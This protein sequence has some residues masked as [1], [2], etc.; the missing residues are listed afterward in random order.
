MSDRVNSVLWALHVR[1]E[2]LMRRDVAEFRQNFAD[3]SVRVFLI[4]PTGV[5]YARA[6]E[7]FD[8]GIGDNET[9]VR[10]PLMTERALA[11]ADFAG[12]VASES[13]NL[14]W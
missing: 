6:Y 3:G 11:D 8:T 7:T 14:V 12:W 4:T 10:L 1:N 5:I 13:V 9:F 2:N